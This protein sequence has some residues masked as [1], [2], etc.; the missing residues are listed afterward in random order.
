M[1]T[2]QFRAHLV[3]DSLIGKRFSK[4]SFENINVAIVGFCPPPATLGNYDQEPLEDQYF[5]HVSPRSSRLIRFDEYEVLSLE[6]IYGGPVASSTV[7]S[8]P[9]GGR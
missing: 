3:P 2:S 8:F 5:I 9:R 6:H 4:D 1:I 7:I